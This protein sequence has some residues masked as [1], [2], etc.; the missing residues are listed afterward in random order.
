M[1]PELANQAG[2]LAIF[3]RMAYQ[4]GRFIDREQVDIFKNDAKLWMFDV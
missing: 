3:R 1:L 2:I 4:P